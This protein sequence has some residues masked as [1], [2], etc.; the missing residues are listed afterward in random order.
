MNFPLTTAFKKTPSV[1][2]QN[3]LR[4]FWC[5][6]VVEDPKPQKNDFEARPLK[7]FIIK[8]IVMNDKKPL[9]LDLKPSVNPL[10]LII[11]K[12]NMLPIPLLRKH[13][14][15]LSLD[16]SRLPDFDLF[17]DQEE[18]SDEEV[19]E[20]MAETMEQYMSKTRDDYGLGIARPKIKD[21]DSFELKG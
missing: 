19:A 21:K 5:S 8:F 3:I 4:E 18:Y 11:T 17:S 14:K 9:T 20:T 16:E 10:V 2:Y 6:V 15:T 12:A 1:L 7:E 13:F